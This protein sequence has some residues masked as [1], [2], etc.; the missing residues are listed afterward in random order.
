[1]YFYLQQIINEIFGLYYVIFLGAE[2]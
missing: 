2:V 1:M